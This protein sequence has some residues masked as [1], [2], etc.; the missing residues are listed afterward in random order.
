M[1]PSRWFPWCMWHACVPLRC[2]DVALFLPVE[3]SRQSPKSV[4]SCSLSLVSKLPSSPTLVSKLS[5]SPTA[6]YRA[7]TTRIRHLSLL[8]LRFVGGYSTP[9]IPPLLRETF[10]RLLPT[11]RRFLAYPSLRVLLML[12]AIPPALLHCSLDTPSTILTP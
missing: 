7:V 6:P 4:Q 1:L 3:S 9:H 8:L 12:L 2:R 11:L 10:K 5:S